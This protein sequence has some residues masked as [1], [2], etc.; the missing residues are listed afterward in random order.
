MDSPELTTTSQL[1]IVPDD[2]GRF[3]S[4]EWAL[5][6]AANVDVELLQYLG[7]QHA[8]TLDPKALD[9][10]SGSLVLLS[11]SPVVRID[12]EIGVHEAPIGHAT[13][14]GRREAPN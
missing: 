2:P 14:R 12:Q 6:L 10:F 3:F 11:T 13:R 4:G 9:D 8:G 5:G 7:A 1:K